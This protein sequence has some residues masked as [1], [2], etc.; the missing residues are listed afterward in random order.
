MP[1]RGLKFWFL[2]ERV[3]VLLHIIKVREAEV[4]KTLVPV[5]GPAL[6]IR[7]AAIE[8]EY[9][10]LPFHCIQGCELVKER[11]IIRRRVKDRVVRLRS[12]VSGGLRCSCRV[13]S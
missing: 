7:G 8:G 10:G 6:L 1:N 5:I 2:E 9:E 12:G 13:G 3:E 4:L 11:V